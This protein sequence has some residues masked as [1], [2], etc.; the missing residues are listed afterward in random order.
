MVWPAV[1]STDDSI[2]ITNGHNGVVKLSQDL[3]LICKFTSCS[4][5]DDD[6]FYRGVAVVGDEVMVCD[7]SGNNV[8]VFTKELK[9]VRQI[10]SHGGPEHVQFGKIQDVTSDEY[11][12]LYISDIDEDRSR[13]C[14]QV[15]SNGGEFIRTIGADRLKRLH[16]VAVSGHYVYVT[17]DEVNCVSVFTTEGEYV[18]SFQ[19]EFIGPCGVCVD[20][21]G[22]VYVCDFCCRKVQIF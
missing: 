9:Y 4:N 1:D 7:W 21:D 2:Y 15:Y 8:K 20:K 16:G 17:D 6:T 5:D 14:V 13:A 3:K 10:N 18:T 19:S 22:F 12:N 11:G